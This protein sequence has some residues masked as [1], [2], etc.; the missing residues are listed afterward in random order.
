MFMQRVRSHRLFASAARFGAS[1][2]LA[3]LSVPASEAYAAKPVPVPATASSSAAPKIHRIVF[4]VTVDGEE[5]WNS[6]LSQIENVRKGLAPDSV[7]IEVVTHGNATGFVLARNKAVSERI[8]KIEGP[9]VIFAY[10]SNTQKKN[11]V[12][13]EELTPGVTIIPSGLVEVIKRQEE[14]W[15][16]IK[17][18]S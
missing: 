4:Q 13:A 12:K 2:S 16:Y 15:S 8:Q 9:G 10:C 6:V 14:G 17:G 1:L 5:Q 18:G 3:A 11:N 7:Q